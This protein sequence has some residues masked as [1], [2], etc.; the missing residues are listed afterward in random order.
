[1]LLICRESTVKYFCPLTG[2]RQNEAREKEHLARLIPVP[3]HD[4]IRQA[5]SGVMK[6]YGLDI[7][8]GIEGD[9]IEEN[10]AA[11]IMVHV[12]ATCQNVMID[13]FGRLL[14]SNDMPPSCNVSFPRRGPGFQL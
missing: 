2:V 11:C 9:L 12:Q 10:R 4:L 6:V 5:S 3:F 8:V 1:M 13:I 14:E 7:D